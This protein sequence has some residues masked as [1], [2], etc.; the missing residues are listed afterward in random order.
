MAIG[1]RNPYMYQ[2]TWRQRANQA[3]EFFLG[4]SMGGYHAE[5]TLAGT[6]L[7][8]LRRAPFY[9]NDEPFKLTGYDFLH[10]P[11]R[12]GNDKQSAKDLVLVQRRTLS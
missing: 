4:V 10:A 6:W 5:P 9:L 2:Y 11:I 1:D 8:I 12:R 3:D 7:Y